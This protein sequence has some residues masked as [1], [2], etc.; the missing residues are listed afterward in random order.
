VQKQ[1]AGLP[2]PTVIIRPSFPPPRLLLRLAVKEGPLKHT[3]LALGV[4]PLVSAADDFSGRRYT[5]TPVAVTL[6]TPDG[7]R[8]GEMSVGAQVFS[9]ARTRSIVAD[10]VRRMRLMAAVRAHRHNLPRAASAAAAHGR[11][12]ASAAVAPPDLAPVHSAP[13]P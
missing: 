7:R 9:G 10:A 3:T 4:L 5:P 12:A 1:R 11:P 6:E 8:L 2:L 13:H